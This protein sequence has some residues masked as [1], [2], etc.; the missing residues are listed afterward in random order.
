MK[1]TL[2]DWVKMDE[3]VRNLK[4]AIEVADSQSFDLLKNYHKAGE[5]LD[6]PEVLMIMKLNN[7][8]HNLRQEAGFL[9]DCHPQS[10][11][12]GGDSDDPKNHKL[13][14]PNCCPAPRRHFTQEEMV[15]AGM[16]C[17]G[18]CQWRKTTPFIAGLT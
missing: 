12:M 10:E 7:Q 1:I 3:I 14:E 18:P 15:E 8:L 13:R 17:H 16:V 11:W 2:K 9:L 6:T 4:H 5:S